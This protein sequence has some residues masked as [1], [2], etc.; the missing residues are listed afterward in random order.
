MDVKNSNN[1]PMEVQLNIH[2]Q[3]EQGVEEGEGEEEKEKENEIII[4]RFSNG[5]YYKGQKR[6][7]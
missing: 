6:E 2:L 4:E 3:K 7:K 1:R 5:S